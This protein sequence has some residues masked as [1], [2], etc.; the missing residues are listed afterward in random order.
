MGH[1]ARSTAC[2]LDA[3]DHAAAT[4][5]LPAPAAQG[6]VRTQT[7]RAFGEADI[8]AVL[9]KAPPGGKK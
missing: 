4:A 9:A 5:V 6:N 3:P 8:D 2:V 1:P 7:L